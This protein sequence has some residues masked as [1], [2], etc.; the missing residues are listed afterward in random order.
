MFRTRIVGSQSESQQSA[1]GGG[2]CCRLQRRSHFLV[3]SASIAADAETTSPG[4]RV[5][6]QERRK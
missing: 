1:P 2:L 5:S 3:G 6:T 4:A